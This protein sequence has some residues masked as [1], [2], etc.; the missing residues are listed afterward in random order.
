MKRLPPRS[1]RT[2]TLFPYTTLFRS[3]VLERDRLAL[4]HLAGRDPRD[5]SL[6]QAR[7]AAR[8]RRA[9]DRT[10]RPG[11]GVNRLEDRLLRT[12]TPALQCRP[13]AADS[14]R[15]LQRRTATVRAARAPSARDFLAR[16]DAR[17]VGQE[18]GR[19]CRSR[20]AQ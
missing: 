12:P 13:A 16:T 2:D 18:C 1:T 17:R 3:V 20:G 8:A 9:V 14:D 11:V 5:A 7:I 19:P 10:G 6:E 4:Q 15:Q